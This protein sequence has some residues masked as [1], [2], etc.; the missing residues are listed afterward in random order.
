MTRSGGRPTALLLTGVGRYADP[1]HPFPETTAALAGL[2]TDAG[3]AVEVANDVDAALARLD[4]AD[5]WP[6]L[7]AVNVGLPRDGRPSPGTVEAM[8]G[9]ERWVE[10]GRPLLACHVSS[11]SFVDSQAWEEA[12]GGRWVRGTSMHPEYGPAKILV[13]GCSGPLAGGI[14]DFEV[15]DERYSWLRTSPDIKVH[16]MHRHEGTL[17]PLLWSRTRGGAR[18][19]YDALGHDAASFESPEHLEMLRRAIA[20]LVPDA[21]MQVP[22]YRNTAARPTQTHPTR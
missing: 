17:H 4:P 9:L 8:R 3:I 19:F 7:L 20:W 5:L 6:D 21:G 11:T 16:A 14:P 18:S 22:E 12:L 1:W 13:Q 2:L 15:Q 10:A